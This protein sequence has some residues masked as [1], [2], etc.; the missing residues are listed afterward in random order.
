LQTRLDSFASDCQWIGLYSY[1][2]G[3][4]LD[5]VRRSLSK[6]SQALVRVFALRGTEEVFPV[7]IL[8]VDPTKS[9]DDP[10][11]VI[12]DRPLHPPGSKDYSLTNSK[13]CFK[14]ICIALMAGE[15]PDAE[16]LAELMWD[17]PN[18]SY[19]GPRSEVCTP[20]QQHLAYAIKYL[21]LGQLEAIHKELKQIR[22]R[23]GEEHLAAMAKM[24][25]G[26][27]EKNEVFFTEGLGELLH[28]HQGQVKH[29]RN[30][31]DPEMFMCI[32]ALGLSI[33][34]VRRG[35]FKKT[36]LPVDPYLPLELIPDDGL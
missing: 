20:N 35:L 33:L 31:F 32:P 8:T 7:V 3:F 34:A 30:K 10:A 12:G 27:V 21:L 19:I 16:K 4:P 24:A 28:W 17:P 23:K 13:E 29:P 6:A 1:G 22:C 25:S 36:E 11:F 18:A 9:E 15:Y 2:L 26:L 14:S 5:E